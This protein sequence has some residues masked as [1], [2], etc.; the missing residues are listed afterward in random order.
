MEF[1]V[2]MSMAIS[3]EGRRQFAAFFSADVCGFASMLKCRIQLS[4]TI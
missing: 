4:V 3:R 1:E 2:R